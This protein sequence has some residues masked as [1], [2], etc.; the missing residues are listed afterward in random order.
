[1]S[2]RSDSANGKDSEQSTEGI[3]LTGLEEYVRT[4]SSTAPIGETAS[5]T[6]KRKF[7]SFFLGNEKVSFK[8][9]MKDQVV[10]IL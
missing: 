8:H 3:A 2:K 4:E 7:S 9:L 10:R 1:M 6:L 5:A